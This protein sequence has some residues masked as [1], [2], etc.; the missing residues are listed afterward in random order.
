M[1][2]CSVCESLQRKINWRNDTFSNIKK[3]IGQFNEKGDLEELGEA[4]LGT[5]FLCVRYRCNNCGT[6]WRLTHPDQAFIGGFERE[7]SS[8]IKK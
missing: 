4:A 8:E 3:V 6:V 7:K 5:P 1:T 2:Q